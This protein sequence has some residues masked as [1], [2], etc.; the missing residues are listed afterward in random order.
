M[1]RP[2]HCHARF[3]PIFRVWINQ[4]ELWAAELTR[5]RI[6]RGVHI[7]VTQLEGD[8]RSFIDLDNK[9]PKPFK[10]TKSAD[11]VS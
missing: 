11:Q 6:Q 9:D 8:V 4:V 5:K 7:S 1:A 10:W 3:T 2:P